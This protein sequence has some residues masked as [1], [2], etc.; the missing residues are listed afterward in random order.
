[1]NREIGFYSLREKTQKR[2]E[3]AEK[4]D[5]PSGW[6]LAKNKFIRLQDQ[7]SERDKWV[8]ASNIG[9]LINKHV[10]EKYSMVIH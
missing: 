5:Q 8:K 3:P 6:E 2:S 4:S 10:F 1:M 9:N 7:A